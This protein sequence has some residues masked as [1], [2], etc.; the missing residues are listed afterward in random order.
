MVQRHPRVFAQILLDPAG[1]VKPSLAPTWLGQAG[2]FPSCCER[3]EAL[4]APALSKESSHWHGPKLINPPKPRV[5]GR[6]MRRHLHGPVGK[7]PRADAAPELGIPAGLRLGS[8]RRAGCPC[9]AFPVHP[10]LMG[11]F[12]PRGL[13]QPLLLGQGASR[14]CVHQSCW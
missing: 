14:R 2:F 11:L 6:A 10:T 8:C 7:L 1:P 4:L 3:C 9:I 5:L 13:P 12:T